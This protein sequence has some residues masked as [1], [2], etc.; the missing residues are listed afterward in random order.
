M[1]KILL[2]KLDPKI[3]LSVKELQYAM[4]HYG[5]SWRDI[6]HSSVVAKNRDK[7]SDSLKDYY[8]AYSSI[9]EQF[10]PFLNRLTLK[11]QQD[12]N[13]APRYSYLHNKIIIQPP[14]D[15][16]INSVNTFLSLEAVKQGED[17]T[18][19]FNPNKLSGKLFPYENISH[20]FARFNYVNEL[21]ASNRS[22]LFIKHISEITFCEFIN[23]AFQFIKNHYLLVL[24]DNKKIKGP[25]FELENPSRYSNELLIILDTILPNLIK[26]IEI[27][28]IPEFYNKGDMEED[29]Q[30]WKN[31]CRYV[32]KRK[33]FCNLSSDLILNDNIQKTT[34]V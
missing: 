7:L 11:N 8:I 33:L 22:S 12:K 25:G 29:R 15:R 31:I 13:K 17:I 28:T 32:E 26:G 34:K 5:I 20:Y 9:G 18:F 16:E 24:N 19:R 21:K 27:E 30:R 4:T 1:K 10:S 23:E 2:S 14:F 3:E 6:N